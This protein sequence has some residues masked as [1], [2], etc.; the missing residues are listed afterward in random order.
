MFTDDKIKQVFFS[1]FLF[2]AVGKN[3]PW[4][5]RN[6]CAS[7]MT[8]ALFTVEPQHLTLSQGQSASREPEDD[9]MLFIK[10]R[11]TN[12]LSLDFL[13]W[14]RRVLRKGRLSCNSDASGDQEILLEDQ[15]PL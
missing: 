6:P 1:L 9:A 2:C 8:R 5:L 14:M 4:F 15:T 3:D 10:F 13:N 11:V 12:H 7:H